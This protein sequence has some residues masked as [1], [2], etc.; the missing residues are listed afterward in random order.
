VAHS[1]N[2]F[3]NWRSIKEDYSFI[4][5]DALVLAAVAM[6]R[7]W[8]RTSSSRVTPCDV[9]RYAQ[10]VDRGVAEAEGRRRARIVRRQYRQQTHRRSGY[11]PE[12]VESRQRRGQAQ[13][14]H[15]TSESQGAELQRSHAP[16][17]AGYRLASDVT[18]WFLVQWFPVSLRYHGD[19]RM[20]S[21]TFDLNL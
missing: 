17:P 16:R 20:L 10:E 13:G 12:T 21:L 14:K 6:S 19:D 11:V 1:S 18:E 8:P 9:S 15:Q 3:Y 4:S 7:E 2:F 5:G